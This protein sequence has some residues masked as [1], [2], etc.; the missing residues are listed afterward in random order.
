MNVTQCS[1]SVAPLCCDV[2]LASFCAAA[3]LHWFAALLLGCRGA[4][5]VSAP[6]AQSE[7]K[8]ACLPFEGH[9]HAAAIDS[10]WHAW[11]AT[12]VHA[13]SA[14]K[15]QPKPPGN[16]GTLQAAAA[17][18]ESAVAKFEGAAAR[19]VPGAGRAAGLALERLADLGDVESTHQTLEVGCGNQM[20]NAHLGSMNIVCR[21]K[22]WDSFAALAQD[23]RGATPTMMP[24]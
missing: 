7:L 4:V 8:Q 11:D 2:T 20:P 22:L 24:S 16:V 1:V 23:P 19:G 18:V 13:H 17:A 6:S 9:T 3:Q 14:R 10:C 21:K 12:L 5:N 15:G